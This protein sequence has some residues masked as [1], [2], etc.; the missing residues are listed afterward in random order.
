MSDGL[1]MQPEPL[2]YLGMAKGEPSMPLAFGPIYA[3]GNSNS[4]SD[5]TGFVLRVTGQREGDVAAF[6]ESINELLGDSGSISVGSDGL[7][8][9]EG[10]SETSVLSESISAAVGVGH[11]VSITVRNND[12]GV[13]WDEAN[14][15]FDV[16][17]IA[18][19]G[20]QRPAS[21]EMIWSHEIMEQVYVQLPGT[22]G[23]PKTNWQHQVAA[24]FITNHTGWDQAG[25]RHSTGM[26]PDGMPSSHHIRQSLSF[27]GPD[28]FNAELEFYT[29]HRHSVSGISKVFRP[30]E[31]KE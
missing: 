8:T 10:G 3:A 31:N 28:G 26:G 2:L 12:R 23:M 1:W 18:S 25:A 14:G 17:G 22:D 15:V 24:K 30:R 19:F 6:T 11:E 13:P 20:A 27:D 5:R 16:S 4:G 29:S 7:V 9:F 21:S